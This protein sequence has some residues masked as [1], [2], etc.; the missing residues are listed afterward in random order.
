MALIGKIRK[1]FWF[2]LILLGL[3]LAAFILMDM[4]S[5][6]PGG[7]AVT[8]T[9][10][11]T[12]A[13]SSIDYLDF[14]KTETAYF[15][16]ASGDAF[17]KKQNIW[18]FYVED[19]LLGS[20]G[21]ALGL[22]VSTEELMDLQFGPNPCEI[23][24]QN[25]RNP[26]TGQLDFQSLQSFKTALEN[27]DELNP[28][29]VDYWGEQEKQIIK[30]RKQSKLNNLVKK[31]I[32]TPTW[33]AEESF[34]MDN[35]KVDFNYVKVPFDRIDATGVEVSNSDIASYLALNK[36]KYEVDEETRVVEFATFD[37]IPSAAD[38]TIVRDQVSELKR[39][40]LAAENDSLF[41]TSNGGTYSH[42]YATA[43][44]LPIESRNQIVGLNSGETYGPYEQNGLYFLVKMVDKRSIPD[45]VE[46]RHILRRAVKTDQASVAAARFTID[47]IK[48]QLSRGV[49]FDT[50]ALRHSQDLS[51]N[52]RGGSLGEF[53]QNAMVPEF[54]SAC[55]VNGK[56]GGIYTVTT[57]YGVHLLEVQSQTFSNN[58][59]KYRIATMAKPI[60]PSEDTQDESFNRVS[61]LLA[62][63]RDIASLRTALASDGVANFVKSSPLKANDFA[64]GNL[65]ATD[66]S[67]QIV[68]WAFDASTE[69]GDVSPDV[70]KF[71]NQ[72]LYTDSKY[73]LAT[74]T[75]II[76]EG[77]PT[78]DAIRSEVEA[79]V[80][81]KLKA[82]KFISGLNYT[83]IE[84]AAT[85]NAAT[86]ETASDVGS[87]SSFIPGL[88]NEK[89]VLAAALDLDVQAVSKPILGESGV[90]IIQPIS[91]QDA[92]P[93]TN[94]AG[95]KS[96]ITNTTQ[97]QVDFS[98]I[99]NLK[100]RANIK[101]LRSKFF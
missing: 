40:L 4:N 58:D 59:L 69:V 17:S 48:T 63:N 32:F 50:L 51:N 35:T 52:A 97:S 60:K 10:M 5:A 75:S 34:K 87:K 65:G 99:K 95:L 42:L 74:L 62:E 76:P 13:G 93:S 47:S 24:Q 7:G 71:R 98:I 90:Y 1:N 61:D 46:A 44:E 14:Q 27:G 89:S 73:V 26:Q 84:D 92:G 3:A 12:I 33:M 11:G 41:I 70:Y 68:K 67:R 49:S 30:D 29:F 53:A 54:A 28:R 78:P 25:W 15:A 19:A 77:L 16:N 94:V 86:V 81:N 55:F 82:E 91:K 31:S 2:V 38:S 57:D 79:V 80:L 18:N 6:G 45:T 9:S 21:D 22:N 85:Q 39:D 23:I 88:G 96:G 8:N 36:S 101:D 66:G 56:R 72:A 100:E 43:E 20:E 37:V 83:S 64:V